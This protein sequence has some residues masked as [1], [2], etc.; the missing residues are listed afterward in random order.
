MVPQT[1]SERNYLPRSA[2]SGWRWRGVRKKVIQ[3]RPTSPLDVLTKI[4]LRE[5]LE[6]LPFLGR[7]VEADSVDLEPALLVEARYLVEKLLV[8][9][10]SHGRGPIGK[11]VN[12]VD[13]RILKGKLDG[14]EQVVQA[15]RLRGLNE[16]L[17]VL[18]ELWAELGKG[19]G[20]RRRWR[21]EVDDRG[22][23]P[24]HIHAVS[25]LEALHHIQE[26][27]LGDFQPGKALRLGLGFLPRAL[28]S[29]LQGLPFGVSHRGFSAVLGF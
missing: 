16:A 6:Q 22:V 27:L 21:R 28:L 1:Q 10:D 8:V 7:W 15:L 5:R 12:R 3:P 26:L 19:F 29:F 2:R 20:L 11:D 14:S 17:E 23:E 18:S 9:H 13:L 24:K 25:I 4:A